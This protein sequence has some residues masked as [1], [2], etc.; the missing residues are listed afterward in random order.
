MRIYAGNP[1]AFGPSKLVAVFKANGKQNLSLTHT[2]SAPGEAPATDTGLLDSSIY[3]DQKTKL[4]AE[5]GSRLPYAYY[6]EFGTQKIAARP[7]WVPAV[8]KHRATLQRLIAA[9]I[10]KATANAQR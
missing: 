8:E 3:F 6:L 10:K 2:S 5:I 7:S 4:S 9:E 1:D